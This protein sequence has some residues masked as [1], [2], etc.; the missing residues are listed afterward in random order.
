MVSMFFFFSSKTRMSQSLPELL[1]FHSGT[2][3][4]AVK[5]VA[6]IPNGSKPLCQQVFDFRTA[7]I[8]QVHERNVQKGQQVLFRMSPP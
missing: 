4:V 7:V 1:A 2:M 8:L 5:M 6:T 3:D